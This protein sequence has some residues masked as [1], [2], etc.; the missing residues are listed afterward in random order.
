MPYLIAN[1]SRKNISY[2]S[3]STQAANILGM[4]KAISHSRSQGRILVINSMRTESQTDLALKLCI[5]SNMESIQTQQTGCQ[6][7]ISRE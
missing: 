2:V 7:S 3:T 6:F 4:S 1:D 5:I